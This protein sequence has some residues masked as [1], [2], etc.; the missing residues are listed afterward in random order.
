MKK[1]ALLI[2]LGLGLWGCTD[3]F[4]TEPTMPPQPDIADAASGYKAGFYWLPPIVKPPLVTGNFDAGLSPV[5]EICELVDDTCGPVIATFTTT[6]GTG[7][8]LVQV[9]VENEHYFVKWHTDRFLL[10]IDAQYR[11]SVRAGVRNVLLGYADVQ[12]VSTG[13]EL[14]NVNTGEYIGLVDG[15]TLNIK[16]RIET[17]IVAHIEV[18]P[19]EA[20]TVPGGNQ[21]FVAVARDLHDQIINA[22]V[23]WSSSDLVVAFIDHTGLAVALSEG[24]TTITATSQRISG[25]ATFIVEGGVVVISGGEEHSCTLGKGSRAYCWGQG[26]H[27]QLGN[28]LTVRQQSPVAVAGELTFAAISTGG[29]HTCALTSAGKAY[30]WGWSFWGQVGNGSPEYTICPTAHPCQLTPSEVLGGHSFVSISGGHRNTCALTTDYEAYCWGA[31]SFGANGNGT[32]ADE[33]TPALVA[34]GWDFSSL[35]SG[36][37]FAC[38]VTFSGVVAC[39][40]RGADGRLGNGTTVSSLIPTTVAGGHTFTSITTGNNHAC[41][42]TPSGEAYCW[43]HNFWGKLGNGASGSFANQSTP[44]RVSG[45]LLFSSISAGGEHTCGVTTAGQGYCW[46]EGSDGELGIGGFPILRNT[47]TPISGG[48]TWQSIEVGTNHSCGVTVDN[49]RYCWGRSLYIGSSPVANT[50]PSLVDP[51]P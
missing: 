35:S 36:T 41:A 21:Q 51:L 6:S 50:V 27:G 40:G 17:G 33:R 15:R 16:F 24:F 38:G 42:L 25:S 18:Q 30:C 32:L 45:G 49:Q 19:P 11:V 5:V 22:D 10:N 26:W 4:P 44:V 34:G 47:P 2:L 14:R 43:G 8:E 48:L 29:N 39:W 46:G 1:R 28:G 9:N 13:R 23:T 20:T 37:D 3:Q 31:G 7:D 12:L